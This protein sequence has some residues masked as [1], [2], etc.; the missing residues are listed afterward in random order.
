[1]SSSVQPIGGCGARPPVGSPQ[2]R[3]GG[4]GGGGGPPRGPPPRPFAPPPPPPPPPAAGGLASTTGAPRQSP[5]SQETS[6]T[7]R[8][9]GMAISAS[10]SGRRLGAAMPCWISRAAR[11]PSEAAGNAATSPSP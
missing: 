1:M 7:E 6:P 5:P 4:R 10:A 11:S 8:P 9:I 2:P 3:G